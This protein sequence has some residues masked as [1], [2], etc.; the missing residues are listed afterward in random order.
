MFDCECR[1]TQ[2][3]CLLKPLYLLCN[4]SRSNKDRHLE[5]VKIS[6]QNTSYITHLTSNIPTIQAVW[7]AK[8]DHSQA[9]HDFPRL[10][11]SFQLEGNESHIS[12][13][14]CRLYHDSSVYYISIFMLTLLDYSKPCQNLNSYSKLQCH[15]FPQLMYLKLPTHWLV[16]QGLTA[17]ILNNALKISRFIAI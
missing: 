11:S 10:L 8:M 2:S 15:F 6:L 17:I 14:Y 12:T 13:M 5:R 9:P 7:Q 4:Q 3:L 16:H 1:H